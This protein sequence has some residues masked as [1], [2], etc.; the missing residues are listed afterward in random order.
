MAAKN[1]QDYLRRE[2]QLSRF[3]GNVQETKKT[4]ALVQFEN[5]TAKKQASERAKRNEKTAQEEMAFIDSDLRERRRAALKEFHQ[6]Q[7]EM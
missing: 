4:A 6:Q 1:V 2:E 7:E 5:K 3:R